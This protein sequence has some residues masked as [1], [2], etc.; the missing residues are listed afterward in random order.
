MKLVTLQKKQKAKL[1]E[2]KPVFWSEKVLI[3]LQSVYDYIFKESPE[4]ADLVVD[5][6]FEIG[7]KLNIFPEK[8]Q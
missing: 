5:T 3:S 2:S 7:D 8:T 4:N 6:L 1:I